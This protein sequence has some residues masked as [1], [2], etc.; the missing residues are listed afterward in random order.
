MFQYPPGDKIFQYPQ[1]KICP[2]ANMFQYSHIVYY[3]ILLLIYDFS[4][5]KKYR[6]FINFSKLPHH[7]QF[8]K[9]Q[10]RI[11]NKN[12]QYSQRYLWV[13]LIFDGLFSMSNCPEIFVLHSNW[14]TY[15]LANPSFVITHWLIY[16][17]L[18]L[19]SL[20]WPYLLFEFQLLKDVKMCQCYRFLSTFLL[21]FISQNFSSS[22]NMHQTQHLF[23]SH[24]TDINSLLISFLHSLCC[25]NLLHQVIGLTLK[26][27]SGS[28]LWKLT[29]ERVIL[30]MSI[31]LKLVIAN[32]CDNS[33]IY[34][35]KKYVIV[36]NYNIIKFFQ[37]F[38]L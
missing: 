15:Y 34:I 20:C 1:T 16:F 6:Y 30:L 29:S 10:N 37:E 4:I 12:R 13:T 5:L 26:I 36:E 14:T 11:T 17:W 23:G 33:G 7:L 31:V 22:S 2:T 3:S 19:Y 32:K 21:F 27:F 35:N 38:Y 9:I 18:S 25:L 28:F 8:I 24:V